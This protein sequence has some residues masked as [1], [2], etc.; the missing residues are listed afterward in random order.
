[1]NLKTVTLVAAYLGSILAAAWAVTHVGTQY[2]PFAP[3][4][5]PVWPSPSIEAPSG[6]YII[7]LTLVLRDL[8]QH[9]VGK[10]TMV[11][12]IVVGAGLSALISPAI[13]LASGAAFLI[14]ESLDYGVFT[15]TER[16][17]FLRAVLAS[18]AVSLVADSIVFLVVA[19]GSLQYVEGQIIGKALA[20]LA[21]V[22]VIA[23]L[24]VR[25]VVTA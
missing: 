23:T 25:R 1:M 12:L 13:A 11:A 24:R 16:F 7:G 20:T 4:V 5:L 9:R 6:V 18:N 17:G 3:H 21:A 22:A 15:L 14:S 8:L 2:A 10:V 19:F